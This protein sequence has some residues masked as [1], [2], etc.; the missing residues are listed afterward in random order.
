MKEKF[1]KLSIG[2]KLIIIS[3][4]IAIISLP[5]NWVNLEGMSIAGYSQRAYIVL[6]LF[7]YPLYIV[8]SN[9]EMDNFIAYIFAIFANVVGMA[10]IRIISTT[11]LETE[12]ISY[13]LGIYI[14]L[15]STFLLLFGVFKYKKV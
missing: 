10:Y 15:A 8:I 12:F 13:G 9:K 2:G 14:Y 7:L 11:F 3:V 4:F 1:G 6:L 5:F